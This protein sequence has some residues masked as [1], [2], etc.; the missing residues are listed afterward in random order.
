[1]SAH[2]LTPERPDPELLCTDK[3]F[4]GG[5]SILLED[6]STLHFNSA[7]YEDRGD[8]YDVYTEHC[9]YHRLLKASVEQISDMPDLYVTYDDVRVYA[10]RLN[11]VAVLCSIGGFLAHWGLVHLW[12]WL[13]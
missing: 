13:Q 12:A 8:F 11:I 3:R 10:E 1:M 2:I 9:G 4:N 6:G 5:L 7:F